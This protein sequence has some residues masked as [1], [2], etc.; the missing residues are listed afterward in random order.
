[1]RGGSVGVTG[2]NERDFLGKSLVERAI[3]FAQTLPQIDREICSTDSERIADIA[4]KRGADVPEL[5]PEVLSSSDAAKPDVWRYI[6]E[7]SSSWFGESINLFCDFDATNPI[8][9]ALHFKHL[10]EVVQNSSQYD[11][12]LLVKH[13]RKNPYFN[14]GSRIRIRKLV[15]SK[16]SDGMTKVVARQHAPPVFEH[17]ASMYV[18]KRITFYEL[19]HSFLATYTVLKSLSNFHLILIQSLTGV[20]KYLYTKYG[21]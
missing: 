13:A 5:R 17:I 20:I 3:N 1:M 16:R 11:G 12:A 9:S 8:K 6:I 2:K 15:I 10:Y 14:F 7:N 4:L 21:R 18:L 19:K